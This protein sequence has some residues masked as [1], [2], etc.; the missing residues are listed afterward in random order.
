[1]ENCRSDWAEFWNDRLNDITTTPNPDT[2]KSFITYSYST[3]HDTTQQNKD[4]NYESGKIL[5]HDDVNYYKSSLSQDDKHKSTLISWPVNDPATA[6]LQRNSHLNLH[7][8]V[9]NGSEHY[10]NNEI[11]PTTTTR[12]TYFHT[13]RTTK[14]PYDFSD[15]GKS[16]A[17]D[18]PSP[19]IRSVGNDQDTTI[20]PNLYED[21]YKSST[22]KQNAYDE[23]YRTSTSKN[24]L[25]DEYYKTSTTKQNLYDYYRTTPPSQNIF[26]DYYRTSSTEG[27]NSYAEYY[28]T[29]TVKSNTYEE[30]Y[31]TSSTPAPHTTRN[32]YDFSVF[33]QARQNY[34]ARGNN[35]YTSTTDNHDSHQTRSTTENPYAAYELYYKTSTTTRPYY[36]S[37]GTSNY[38]NHVPAGSQS[39]ESSNPNSL[40]PQSPSAPLYLDSSTKTGKLQRLKAINTRSSS[41]VCKLN[42]QMLIYCFLSF[43]IYFRYK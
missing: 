14:S 36:Q 22:I 23:Y 32:P 25:Y 38:E 13:F 19:Q 42:L 37:S 11:T 17:S 18:S 31:R 27:P 10:Q 6:N 7:N 12:S 26:E 16:T 20:K 43:I 35:Y 39:P 1:M 15:F 8:I 24:N 34:E 41:D 30:Y 29:S 40:N 4:P 5:G 3:S 2:T 9:N 28:R 21:Y 33:G